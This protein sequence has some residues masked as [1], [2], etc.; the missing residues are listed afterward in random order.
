M[1]TEGNGSPAPS[2]IANVWKARGQIGCLPRHTLD[3]P[4]ERS[5]GAD[6]GGGHLGGRSAGTGKLVLE[7]SR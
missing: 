5:R 4:I 3:G 2:R 7:M 6:K 1:T